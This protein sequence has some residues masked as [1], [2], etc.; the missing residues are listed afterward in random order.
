MAHD[1]NDPLQNAERLASLIQLSSDFFWETDAEHRFTLLTIGSRH[2]STQRESQIGKRRWEVPSVAPGP[3]GWA[4]LEAAMD[5]HEVFHDFEFARRD[6]EGR[7][8]YMMTSGEPR[9]DGAGRFLGYRG[10]GRD[11]TTLRETERSLLDAT[12]RFEALVQLS[13]D[14]YWETDA[15]HRF[16]VLVHGPRFVSTQRESQ[17]GKRRWEIGS[18]SPDAAGWAKL[19][20]DMNEHR[21]FHDFEY[22]RANAD[23][24]VKHLSISGEPRI[25]GDGA[26]LGYRGV[27]RDISE[28]VAARER[29]EH[30][31]LHDGL[32]GLAN[33]A[34]LT[35]S[36]VRAMA[37]ARRAAKALALI[38][39]DLDG[40][41]QVNDTLGHDAGDRLL[42]EVANRL[43]GC[44]RAADLQARFGGDEFVVLLED[45]PERAAAGRVAGK[46]LEALG[47]PYGALEGGRC[48]VTASLGIAVF[49]DD[50]QDDRALMRRA[51]EAM[52]LAKLAGKNAYRYYVEEKGAQEDRSA[53]A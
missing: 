46:I 44:L 53:G 19:E 2:K 23:G 36:L 27:G 38:F 7:I 40:F 29:I 32:T 51:D 15:E 6:Q 41:K 20:R 5:A 24:I 10:V 11:I 3:E 50:A 30:L 34:N 8:R 13:S 9:F 39:I 14:F 26:F 1:I 25:S 4:R 43:R 48:R 21:V 35:G 47:R 37:R 28:R 31:A 22:A 33:R 45:L 12:K 42:V 16:T 17:I 52:Y 18:V 49:P